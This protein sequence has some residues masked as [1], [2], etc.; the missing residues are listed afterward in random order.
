MK[1]A[2]KLDE[3][4]G[5]L[6]DIPEVVILRSF[7]GMFFAY[8]VTGTLIKSLDVVTINPESLNQFVDI[9]L[10]GLLAEDD[11]SRL[12]FARRSLPPMG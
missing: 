1:L 9:Y 6:R 10:Y 4:E 2:G 12:E 3:K 5:K 8:Y 11:P 7:L